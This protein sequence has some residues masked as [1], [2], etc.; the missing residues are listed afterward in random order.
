MRKVDDFMVHIEWTIITP[1]LKRYFE[2]VFI[3]CAS[4]IC[5]TIKY[6]ILHWPDANQESGRIF[7]CYS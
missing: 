2:P 3:W 1:A 5:R 7:I 6:E 4:L